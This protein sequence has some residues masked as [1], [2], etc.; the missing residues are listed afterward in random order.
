MKSPRMPAL[1]LCVML[2]LPTLA[3]E[4]QLLRS[5]SNL[6][7][8]SG[9]CL[10][11]PGFGPR[12][13][14]DAPITT[15]TCKYNRPGFSI[16]EEFEMTA[17]QQ[18][19]LPEFDLCLSAESREPGARVYTIDCGRDAAHGW[20]IQPGGRVTPLDARDLCLTLSETVAYVNTAPGNLVPNSSRDVSLQPCRAHQAQFQRWRWSQL[21][22]QNTE[23]ANTLRA[24]MRADIAAGI[25]ELG[26]NV[27][28]A[29]TAALYRDEARAFGP[30]D[31]TVSEPISYGPDPKH[32]L[33]VYTGK[34]RNSPR[35]NAPVLMLVHGG[36]FV[37]GDLSSHARI[38]T[39]FAAL[40]YV[41]VNITYP[42]AP[43]ATWPAG[44]QSVAAA[45]RWAKAN[46]ADL[47]GDPD[48]II[49]F[50]NSA[51]GQH[52]A[53]YALRPSLADGASPAVAGV[54]VASPALIIPAPANG[55]E[56]PYWGD[57]SADRAAKQVLGN[58]ERSSIPML[59]VTAEY[60]P[61]RFQI[62][63]TR[64]LHELVVDHGVGVRTRQLR[65]HN[66]NSYTAGLG[67]AD[68]RLSEEIVDFI[69]TA[70]RAD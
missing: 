59:I 24:G 67:T 20:A 17:S 49:V 33:Q 12:M 10:D 35:N 31:V 61:D 70:A 58:I 18:L 19:R 34:H 40:G 2:P 11:I 14:K 9:Y 51:G 39:H 42:L 26:H 1:L 25:R 6:G 23:T 64:L 4:R 27:R 57:V 53:E 45:V 8:P 22:E 3:Q 63:A 30:A 15:H 36:G 60:D 47:K 16:D 43:A 13:Q 48:T 29:E 62:A 32:Q 55:E 21:A 52:V 50:G 56:N 46:V 69:A 44:S 7:D 28:I 5:V 54:I 66:H 41:V 37:R 68:T 38:A 65:G